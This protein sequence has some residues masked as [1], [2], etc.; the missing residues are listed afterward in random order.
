MAWFKERLET[1]LVIAEK[2]QR[3][4]LWEYPLNA[5]REAIIN[6]ICHRDYTSD[7]HSQIRLYDNRLEI[8]NA[9]KLPAALSPEILLKEHDSIPRNRKIADAFYHAGLIERWGS[10][11]LRMASELK[12]A[13]L[14]EPQF[15]ISGERFRVIFYRDT[16]TEERLTKMG[17]TKRQLSAVKF[18]KERGSI[19]NSEY[20]ELIKV[21][22]RTATR[23]LNQLVSM[24][25]FETAG[26]KGRGSNY[27]IKGPSRWHNRAKPV[28]E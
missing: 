22:K 12:S 27:K 21:S 23:D 26:I 24:D 8:W 2:P 19:S 10:G 3:E 1:K 25:I 5:I 18:A 17:L 20:Q 7:A 13:N 11:T 28:I 4:T 15:E 16:F 9:G 14:P 6:A